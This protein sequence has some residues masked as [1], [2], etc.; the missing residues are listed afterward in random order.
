MTMRS[1]LVVD[2]NAEIREMT[3]AIL[4]GGGYRIATAASG[5]EALA[6]ARES[7]FDLVLLDIDMPVM[8]GWET[9]RLLKADE[10]LGMIPVVMFSV[11]KELSDKVQGM[12]EGAEGYITK[13]FGMDDLLARVRRVLDSRDGAA[14]GFGTAIPAP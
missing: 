6:A 2:D 7:F 9:L 8:D 14:P 11:K 13:P 10:V 4:E 12:Q 1:I 5:R 3:R